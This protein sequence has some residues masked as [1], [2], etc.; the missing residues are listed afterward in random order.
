MKSFLEIREYDSI[1]CNENYK[2]DEVINYL[3]EA[4]FTNL[5][6]FILENNE[7]NKTEAVEFLKITTKRNVG[8]VICAKNYVGLIQTKDGFQIQILP[9]IY[10]TGILETKK[11][12]IRMLRSMKDFP[13]KVFNDAGLRTDNM[14][15]YEIFINMYIQELHNLVKKGVKSAYLSVEDNESF[16]KGKLMIKEHIYCN[17]VHKERFYIKYDEFSVNRPE[18]KLIKSTLMKLSRISKNLQNIKEIQKLL[19]HFGM[20]QLSKN[21]EKDFASV[22]I[23]RSTKDYV[24][25]IKWSKVFLMNQSFTTFSGNNTARALLFPMEKVFEAYVT[26]QLKK[27]LY[28]IECEMSTQDRRYYLFDSPLKFAL[29]PDIVIRVR[30]RTIILDAKWKALENNQK[31][32][33]GISQ[34]DMYQM[35]AYSKKYNTSEIWLLYPLNEEMIQADQIQFVS[36]DDVH[37]RLFFVDLENINESIA[38][39]IEKIGLI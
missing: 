35:Y 25:L 38:S 21:Y 16:Y 5:E 19:N 30:E 12:F 24:N 17:A 22:K 2:N 20:V 31:K 15:L 10:F 27:G 26:Q 28:S 8:K 39:L 37:V 33:Y 36:D 6:N 29:R 13:G 11:I 34:A 3:P 32:N 1:T 7:D 18:N 23:D 4:V 14:N 9:K